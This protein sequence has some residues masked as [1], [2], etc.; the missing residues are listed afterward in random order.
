MSGVKIYSSDLGRLVFF[1]SFVLLGKQMHLKTFRF[2]VVACA[3]P[4]A[5]SC[6]QDTIHET[7]KASKLTKY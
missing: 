6:C 2:A 5:A 1:F 7:K 3:P 4:R